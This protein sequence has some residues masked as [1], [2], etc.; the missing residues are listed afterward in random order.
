M[1][2]CNLCVHHHMAFSPDCLLS[3]HD[4]LIG[5]LVIGLGPSLVQ[6][7]LIWLFTSASYFQISLYS[8]VLRGPLFNSVQFDCF[9]AVSVMMAYLIYICAP[10]TVPNYCGLVV[11]LYIWWN[12]SSAVSTT[13]L[14]AFLG[15]SV[16]F[17]IYDIP[18]W[19]FW[20]NFEINLGRVAMFMI[21][22]VNSSIYLG[23]SSWT[24]FLHTCFPH[25]FCYFFPL[26]T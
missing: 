11:G 4:L 6:Y 8:E 23:L 26:H 16:L 18:F 2:H 21:V 10:T 12:E 20:L 19:N 7:V 22:Y 1:R 24:N 25:F 13:I 3:S 14:Q 15:F 17:K 5:T 9:G